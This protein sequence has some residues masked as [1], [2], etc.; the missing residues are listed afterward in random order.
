MAHGSWLMADGLTEGNVIE[1]GE[2]VKGNRL[3]N[4]AFRGTGGL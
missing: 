2:E 4:R 1:T 3:W